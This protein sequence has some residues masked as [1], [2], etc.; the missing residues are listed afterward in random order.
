MTT[1]QKILV[2]TWIIVSTMAAATLGAMTGITAAAVKV[3]GL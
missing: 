3:F 1:K 2:A